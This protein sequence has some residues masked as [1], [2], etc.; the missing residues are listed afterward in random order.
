M[1][2]NKGYCTIQ[3]PCALSYTHPTQFTTNNLLLRAVTF[4][5]G[6]GIPRVEH[7]AALSRPQLGVPIQTPLIFLLTQLTRAP[8]HFPHI[9]TCQPVVVI[10]SYA[11]RSE[12]S[13]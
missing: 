5:P 6:P 12:G 9:I 8:L 11:G 2:R 7:S 10:N 13:C 1:I 4:I 3:K